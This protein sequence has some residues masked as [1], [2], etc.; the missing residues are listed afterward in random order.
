MLCKCSGKYIDIYFILRI[1]CL[2]IQFLHLC[3][4]FSAKLT[5]RF[6]S[7]HFK[8][9]RGLYAEAGMLEG[10]HVWVCGLGP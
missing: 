8:F 9:G 3:M 2:G 1:T 10:S 4:C 5:A 7:L 6:V